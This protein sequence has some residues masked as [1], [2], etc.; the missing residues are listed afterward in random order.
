MD[1]AIGKSKRYAIIFKERTAKNEFCS[2]F[3]WY[4]ALNTK[5]TEYD[6]RKYIRQIKGPV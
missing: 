1:L 2:F 5:R 4:L 6:T 3:T